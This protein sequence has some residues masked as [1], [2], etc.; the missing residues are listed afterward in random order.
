MFGSASRSAGADDAVNPATLFLSRAQGQTEFLL[1]LPGEE[2]ADGVP[3]PAGRGDD[4]GDRGSLGPAQQRDDRG[5]FR[6]AGHRGSRDRRGWRACGP[7]LPRHFDPP[8]RGSVD[9]DRTVDDGAAIAPVIR[10]G[11]PPAPTPETTASGETH[12]SLDRALVAPA[13]RFACHPAS[14]RISRVSSIG[15]DSFSGT[16]IAAE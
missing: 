8:P 13:Y 9:A 3:L 12:A 15:C 11:Q 1:Q 6:L 4:L 10:S 14:Q 7:A 16:R 5:L 2:T